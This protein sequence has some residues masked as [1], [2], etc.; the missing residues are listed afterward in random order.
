M[1]SSEQIERQL[2]Q[3]KELTSGGPAEDFARELAKG[4]FG[5]AA[6]ELKAL[7]EK[8]A[9]NKLTEKEREQLA[10]QLAEM[11]KQLSQMANMEERRK[12]LEEAH[13]KGMI[14][15]KEYQ[16]QKQ[17]LD[18]QSKGMQALQKLADKLGEAQQQMQN[19]NQQ[20]A[21]QTLKEA[22]QQVGE[23]AQELEQL[24]SLDAAMADLQELK[25]AM[26][27]E[28]MNQLG[29]QLE[30]MQGM[31]MGN[32]PGNG[33]QGLGRGRGQGDR[34]EAPDD[35]AAYDSKVKQQITKGKAVL[36]GFANPSKQVRGESIL[37]VQGN[38]DAAV[39]AESEAL[40]DQKIPNYL[41]KHV[42][43]YYDNVRKGE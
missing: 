39:S 26:N 27:G 13:K 9:N 22:A 40:T 20:Q 7:Q 3:L 25:N 33:G 38:V 32:R 17:K 10:K 41:K 16:E 2:Q 1:G 19:G 8:M 5:K 23:M 12:Q 18:Q 43:A 34:P 24:E 4:E 35:T 29:K 14:S 11:K 6:Q 36:G 42:Q 15:E 28:G 31:G 37:D 30:G 21:A